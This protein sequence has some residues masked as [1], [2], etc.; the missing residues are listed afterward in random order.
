MKRVVLVV[1]DKKLRLAYFKELRNWA[2]YA[3]SITNQK[4][5][6]DHLRVAV[7]SYAMKWARE[8]V[9]QGR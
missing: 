7:K 5:V 8:I 6:P 4:R 9:L 1:D 3:Q 2:K